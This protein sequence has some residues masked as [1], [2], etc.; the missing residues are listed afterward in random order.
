MPRHSVLTC[1]AYDVDD[2]D[3]RGDVLVRLQLPPA[4]EGQQGE[5]R[6]VELSSEGTIYVMNDAGV[7]VD[8]IRGNER[9]RK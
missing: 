9:K 1:V 4:D 8:V 5:E 7:T 2:T 3:A 6:E